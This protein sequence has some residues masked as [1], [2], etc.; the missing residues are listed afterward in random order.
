[1]DI[2][3]AFDYAWSPAI[4]SAMINKGCPMYL[5]R[6]IKDFLRERRGKIT[7]DGEDLETN[8]PTGCPQG[9]VLSAFLWITLKDAVFDIKFPFLT[10]LIAYAD[11]LTV[12]CS[13]ADP[14]RADLNVQTA[15]SMIVKWQ[16]SIKLSINASKSTF[17]MF[18]WRKRQRTPFST[19]I[20]IMKVTFP[21]SKQATFL[22][23][24]LDPQLKWNL[25][26][27]N[28]CNSALRT[29]HAIRQCLGLSWGLSRK[30]LKFLYSCVIEPMLTYCCSAW[31]SAALMPSNKKKLRNIQRRIAIL[32]LRVFRTPPTDAS[33]VLSGLTPADY[34]IQEI[35][36]YKFLTK[37][38]AQS[39]T[40]SSSEIATKIINEG[41][42]RLKAS[43]QIT[44]A[45]KKQM[46]KTIADITRRRWDTE[47]MRSS[48][49]RLTWA[50]FPNTTTADKIEELN[51]P[52]QAAQLFTGHC[53]LN[54][55]LN[56]FTHAASP[57][58]SCGRDQE[59]VTHFMFR[60][61]IFNETRQIFRHKCFQV[62]KI[63]P[64]TL[65]PFYFCPIFCLAYSLSRKLQLPP[66]HSVSCHT[67]NFESY[68]YLQ[69]TNLSLTT[70]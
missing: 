14:I 24:T 8:I 66:P 59:S 43:H 53:R 19:T 5:V 64:P 38:E 46:K 18:D 6:T 17:V 58:C 40:P 12:C 62:T 48:T 60:C 28:K 26:I 31:V 67:C 44:T 10:Y 54:L 32:I 23:L 61:P 35:T 51:I 57:M 16:K 20:K 21:P 15:C 2:K 70:Q 47:W 22:G 41:S 11:D 37:A 25:H 56:R 7:I 30:R 55:Y 3:S 4:L 29:T 27:E 65:Q 49:G 36:T 45:E 63:W 69:S 42:S 34:K 13:D 52:Y 33:L 68:I 9:S 39:F 1:L 50:F